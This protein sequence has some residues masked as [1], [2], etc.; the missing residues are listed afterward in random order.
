MLFSLLDFRIFIKGAYF[1]LFLPPHPHFSEYLKSFKHLFLIAIEGISK[2]IKPKVLKP[3]HK[4]FIT[5]TFY[6]SNCNFYYVVFSPK[7]HI[8]ISKFTLTKHNAKVSF[9][10][11][12]NLFLAHAWPPQFMV[13]LSTYVF[14]RESFLDYSVFLIHHIHII[15]QSYQFYNYNRLEPV[16]FP[17]FSYATLDQASMDC[18]SSFLIYLSTFVP[19][20]CLYCPLSMLL[21][22]FLCFKLRDNKYF[23]NFQWL[24]FAIRKISI[25]F[26]MFLNVLQYIW[27]QLTL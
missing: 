1:F 2:I 5:N 14:R 19:A 26:T 16:T 4:S 15:C 3:V 25:V 11:T 13:P 20:H 23:K 12:L 24:T 10:L 22:G 18:C 9:P 21:Y 8:Y 6:L 27:A 17:H 7:F